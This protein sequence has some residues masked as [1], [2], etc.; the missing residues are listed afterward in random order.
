[1]DKEVPV[2]LEQNQAAVGFRDTMTLVAGLIGGPW[3]GLGTGA[4]S[5]VERYQLGGLAGLASGVATTLLGLY[6][7][8][9]R[10]RYPK[11]VATVI[12]VF[13]VAIT[14][15]L[16]QRLVILMMVKPFNIALSLGWEV[17]VPV[18]IVNCLGCILFFWIMTDLDKDRWEREKKE[19]LLRVAQA[20]LRALRAQVE[21]HFLNNTLHDLNGLIRRDPDKARYYVEELAD[22]FHYTRQFVELD[23]I[24]LADEAD[25]LRRYLELQRLGL[26]EKL[27]DTISISHE[28]LVM[29]VLPGCLLTLVENALKHGFEGRP[30]PYQ[31]NIVAKAE[32]EYLL[33]QVCDNGWGIPAERLSELGQQ[34]VVSKNKGGGVA[35]HQLLQS[36]R[37]I[38][39]DSVK[40]NFESIP[41]QFTT[42]SLWQPIR[43]K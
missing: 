16:L 41:E 39:G 20:E 9:L 22:F 14:G 6:A 3:V 4:L 29:P 42:V 8:M 37:F 31:L 7:G 23:T 17:L 43:R 19:A 11:F 21:P 1:M 10:Y 32:G 15:T 38:F 27:R 12:G 34:P 28:L 26:A 2:V 36:L 40:M 30:A 33:L 13:V 25:Q 18:C 5:G 24:S 35:L